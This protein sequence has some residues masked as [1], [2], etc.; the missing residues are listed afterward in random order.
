MDT[1]NSFIQNMHSASDRWKL[2]HNLGDILTSDFSWEDLYV[3][4]ED[5]IILLSDDNRKKAMLLLFYRTVMEERKNRDGR[6]LYVN[7]D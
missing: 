6:T 5:G 1:P 7:D 2:F 3:L 4:K